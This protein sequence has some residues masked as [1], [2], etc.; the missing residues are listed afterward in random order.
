MRS[1]MNFSGLRAP[2]DGTGGGGGGN[3]GGGADDSHEAAAAKLF[4]GGDGGAKSGS[5]AGTGAATGAGA[6]G[7]AT[8]DGGAAKA[9]DAAGAG[10]GEDK[11]TGLLA[12]LGKKRDA[13]SGATASDAA[14][15]GADGKT[16][17]EGELPEDKINLGDK[18]SPE[19]K[20]H[21]ASVKALTKQLRGDLAA[22]DAR[23]KELET[24]ISSGA[25]VPADYE[26]LRAEHKAFS[27]RVAVLDVR[28]HPDFVKQF[29]EPKAKMVQSISAVLGDNK[30]EGVD[31]SSLLDKPR[32]EF[33][34]A[35]NE[36]AEK[37][38]DYDRFEF[39]A[40][41]RQLY[42]LAQSEKEA[43]SKS[44]E[45]MKGLQAKALS[46]QREA[47]SK[48]WEKLG[49]MSEF[50]VKLEADPNA[51]AEDKA[52]IEAYN[53]AI[54]G[55]RTQAETLAFSPG[56]EEGVAQAAAKAASFDFFV[57]HAFPRIEAEYRQ[58]ASLVTQLQGEL[59]QLR[60]SK[61]EAGAGSSGG[62]GG[63]S[64]EP[65]MSH[66]AAA[67]KVWSS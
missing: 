66:E 44:G 17:T 42:Q 62:E 4:S 59:K 37:L 49:G 46:T 63:S 55:V 53:K 56:G 25:A 40:G 64:G 15:K 67:R 47:F 54:D 30:I 27:E 43:L 45:L 31:I 24:K 9:G 29:T 36:V 51:T 61:A 52:S 39:M 34:K 58:L 13:A 5:D 18:A 65:E 1:N 26:K 10:K 12:N 11:K 19:T 33:M 50:L 32:A 16:A 3:A 41:A 22:R 57:S 14:K 48:T 20:Q 8:S 60:G 21:F 23:I 6:D 28:S 2:E 38:P 35:A 7:K